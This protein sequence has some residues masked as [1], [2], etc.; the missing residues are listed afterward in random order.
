MSRKQKG[1]SVI[2]LLV[3]VATIAMLI[4]MLLPSLGTAREHAYSSACASNQRHVYVAFSLYADEHRDYYPFTYYWWRGL[5]QGGYLGAGEMHGG[6]TS[7]W[8]YRERRWAAFR[9]PAEKGAV[10]G[11][12]DPNCKQPNPHVTAWDSDL[13][14]CSFA[15]QWSINQGRYYV[16]YGD[17]VR[18]RKGFHDGE[19]D[20]PGG[21]SKAILIMDKHKPQWGWVGNYAEWN[22]DTTGG[23][24]NWAYAFR[25]P[26]KNANFLYLDGHVGQR[27][28]YFDSGIP[29]WM[30]VY[31]SN[32]PPP[33]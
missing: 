2:E 3:V 7:A 24:A 32:N 31:N 23:Y 16:G 13:D 22:I 17:T 27:Q 1:F 21:R 8:N 19:I 29:N 11:T 28:H 33:Q 25:H 14:H 20:Y 9:C 4:A 15:Y 10:F 5:G 30:W 26:R 18:S 6:V 12:S